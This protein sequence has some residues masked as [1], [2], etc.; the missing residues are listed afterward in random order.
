MLPGEIRRNFY[1]GVPDNSHHKE[2]TPALYPLFRPPLELFSAAGNL[3][4]SLDKL[5]GCV[6]FCWAT[7]DVPASGDCD[8]SCI[9]GTVL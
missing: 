5:K 6:P 3:T 7:A 9:R 1:P 2:R 4:N 8:W